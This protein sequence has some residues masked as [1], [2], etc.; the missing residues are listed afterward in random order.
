MNILLDRLLDYVEADGR[1][2]KIKTD[3]RVW[4]R[5]DVLISQGQLAPETLLE[6][7]KLCY[8][9]DHSHTMPPTAEKALYALACF[10][11]G[12]QIGN[13][14]KEAQTEKQ[15]RIY[16]FEA[17]ADYI[18]TAFM[19]QYGINLNKIKYL[20]WWEFKALFCGLDDTH[21][22]SKIMEYRAVDLSKIKDKEQKR[23]YTKMKRLYSLPDN[24]TQEQKEAD[25][26]TAFSSII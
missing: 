6:I 13:E 26:L 22:L 10:Y 2:Y 25:M 23:F 24:R 16:S 17:D 8:N 7:L 1:R 14:K 9:L 5:F 20:H 3:F 12:E 4:I 18:Y 21:K 11:T 15:K 19:S